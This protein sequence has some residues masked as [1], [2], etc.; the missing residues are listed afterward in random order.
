VATG[1]GR[2]A[3]ADVTKTPVKVDRL[4]TASCLELARPQGMPKYL[5]D[6][7][8]GGTQFAGSHLREERRRLNAG[9]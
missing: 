1:G 6:P 8:S 2:R 3:G 4:H 5:R 7:T 9:P